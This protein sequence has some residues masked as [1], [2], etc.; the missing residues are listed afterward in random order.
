M[1]SKPKL[2]LYVD[3]PCYLSLNFHPLLG[4]VRWRCLLDGGALPRGIAGG[5]RAAR[6]FCARLGIAHCGHRRLP[7]VRLNGP[8]DTT[9]N[10]KREFCCFLEPGKF[11]WRFLSLTS[12]RRMWLFCARTRYIIHMAPYIPYWFFVACCTDWP[13]VARGLHLR[14][15]SQSKEK[16]PRWI[17]N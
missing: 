4:G 12:T 1:S 16:E 5:S 2:D 10:Q 11:Y 15:V 3:L 14:F 6:C 7:P 13:C 17:I 8:F 9:L